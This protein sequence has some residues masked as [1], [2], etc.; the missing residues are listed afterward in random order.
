MLVDAISGRGE[1][2]TRIREAHGDF[3]KVEKDLMNVRDSIR[4]NAKM[5]FNEHGLKCV[6]LLQEEPGR[7]TPVL[8]I[9]F[10]LSRNFA[11]GDSASVRAYLDLIFDGVEVNARKARIYYD[12][13]QD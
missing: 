13:K 4:P 3:P 6:A 7:L 9:T 10:L 12:F 2:T 1:R 8:N 11:A 5:E